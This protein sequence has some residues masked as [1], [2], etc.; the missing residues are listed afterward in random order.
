MTLHEAV[1]SARDSGYKWLAIDGPFKSIK[2]YAYMDKPEFIPM[3]Q[4][5]Y[6]TDDPDFLVITDR[7]STVLGGQPE[8]WLLH[9]EDQEGP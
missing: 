5:W 7:L 1:Q 6:T 4:E 8:D 3:E 2:V 9:I